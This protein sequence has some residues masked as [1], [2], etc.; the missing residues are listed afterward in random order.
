VLVESWRMP[1]RLQDWPAY[2][3]P[4]VVTGLLGVGL[5]GMALALVIRAGRRSGV[6]LTVPMDAVW[7]YLRDPHTG[8]LALMALL[9]L[10][11]LLALGRGLPYTLVTG[12][13]LVVTMLLFRAAPGWAVLLISAAATAG[14]A[15]VF[16]RIFLIPLP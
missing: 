15:V 16:N 7:R 3:G 9:C 13:Y 12:T 6:S 5:L 2:A 11:Y 4:G 8:R 10:G 1:R 14:I